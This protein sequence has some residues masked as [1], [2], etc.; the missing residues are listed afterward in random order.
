MSDGSGKR[1]VSVAMAIDSNNDHRYT[2]IPTW[3]LTTDQ[4]GIF[5]EDFGLRAEPPEAHTEFE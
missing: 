2:W 5:L 3:T 1:V 4:H